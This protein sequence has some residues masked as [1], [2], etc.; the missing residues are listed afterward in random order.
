MA[1]GA[2]SSYIARMAKQKK[3]RRS[4]PTQADRADKYTLYQ[5]TVQEP[6]HEV[7]FFDRVYAE[8]N[9]RAP[10]VLREDFCGTFAICCEWAK[11]R[12]RRAIG[13]DLDPEPLAWGR[14][15]NL[16]KLTPTQQDRVQIRQEDVRQVSRPKADVLAAQ[17]FSFW[18][19]K[20]RDA[21]RDYFA[22]ARQNLAKDGLMFL[23]MMGGPECMEEDHEDIRDYG[24]FDY[25]WE[26]H[27]FD[28]I[29]HEGTWYIH[30]RFQDGS[31]LERAFTYEWRMWTIP[32]VRELLAE[33][34][35]SNSHVYWEGTDKHGEG[36]GQ[37]KKTTAAASDPAWIAYIVAEK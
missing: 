20:T 7:E 2:K 12:G 14:A 17:N 32:E 36:D 24:R 31:K 9:R 11:K 8:F 6:A 4:G 10:K 26:Q 3:K 27:R 29:S 13:V 30:F 16:A 34:G 18:Y 1:A 33:A 19:F 15:H 21:V 37:W 22:F 25:V 35:F 28:P 5:K 23:D